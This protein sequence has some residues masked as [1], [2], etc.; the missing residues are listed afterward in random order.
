MGI[1]GLLV[2]FLI[3]LW[4]RAPRDTMFIAK[5]TIKDDI[6][7]NSGGTAIEVILKD[8][9]IKKK[10]DQ[11][12]EATIQIPEDGEITIRRREKTSYGGLPFF[13]CGLWSPENKVSYLISN[14]K[15]DGRLGELLVRNIEVLKVQ[16]P[17]PAGELNLEE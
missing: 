14:M 9:T 1:L 8:L 15:G 2:A 16:R 6:N 7:N 12:E 13:T 10:D 5:G 3:F 17:T 4:T 11:S